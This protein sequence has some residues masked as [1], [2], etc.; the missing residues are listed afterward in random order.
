MTTDEKVARLEA[1][2]QLV[3]QWERSRRDP[4]LQAELRST[5][6][7]EKNWVRQEVI[8]A[9]CFKTLTIG[10]PPAIGGMIMNGVDAFQ[11]LFDAPY[12]M[13]LVS[14]VC[15]M[16]DETVGVLRSSPEP[17]ATQ[18]AAPTLQ[19]QIRP[20]YAFVVMPMTDGRPEFDDVSGGWSMRSRC[21][22]SA[23]S[24][25]ARRRLPRRSTFHRCP[26]ARR[27]QPQS[28]PDGSP[29]AFA[30][31]VA[32]STGVGPIRA[33]RTGET[34]P[35]WPSPSHTVRRL[36]RS[37]CTLLPAHSEERPPAT[38]P[39]PDAACRASTTKPSP[40]HQETDGN[41]SCSS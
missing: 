11:M 32:P 12:G 27:R 26:F 5:I 15:D 4:Q 33:A 14:V 6:N 41:G 10:P 29:A 18:Q 31:R 30:R 37:P 28:S 1:F 38:E 3:V 39:R 25:T 17:D 22:R 2:Q 8:A 23:D 13:S 34:G 16:V 36:R 35:R 7:R 20:G 9:H 19:E 40:G 24:P 21:R